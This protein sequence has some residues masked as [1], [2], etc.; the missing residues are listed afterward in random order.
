MVQKYVH[1]LAAWRALRA[2]EQEAIVGRTKLDNVE[3]A[4][5]GAGEQ[6]AHKT[7]AKVEASGEELAILRDNMPFGSPGSGVFGTYFIGYS[8]RLW[9]VEKMLERMFVGDPPGLHDRILDYSR[10]LTGSTFFAP[11][12]GVLAGLDGGDD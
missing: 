6:K 12:A 5:A 7:L 2:E 10:P 4:D 9:V 11:A 1:D 8:R 3:L